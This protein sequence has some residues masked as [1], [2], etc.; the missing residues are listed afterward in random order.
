MQTIKI[1]CIFILKI[2]LKNLKSQPY[3]E[4][5]KHPYYWLFGAIFKIISFIQYGKMSAL[6]GN[7][8]EKLPLLIMLKTIYSLSGKRETILQDKRFHHFEPSQLY[9]WMSDFLCYSHTFLTLT[10]TIIYM[11]TIYSFIWDSKTLI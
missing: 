2:V 5:K 7:L 3:L 8:H 9:L 11:P 4:S 6:S 10:W 1:T